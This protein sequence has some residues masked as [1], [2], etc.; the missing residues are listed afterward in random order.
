MLA[1][2]TDPSGKS[3][4]NGLPCLP[5]CLICP[6]LL[7]VFGGLFFRSACTIGR[8]R[9]QFADLVSTAGG[10][11][12]QSQRQTEIMVSEQISAHEHSLVRRLLLGLVSLVCRHPGWVLF[13]SLALAGASLGAAATRLQY[14]TQR[15]DLISPHKEHQQR[16]RDYLAEFGDDDDIVVVVKGT[17]RPRMEKALEALAARVQA[18]P[19]LFDRLFYKVDLRSLRNRALLFLSTEEIRAI[20]HHLEDMGQLLKH[21][22]IS[23]KLLTL[24]SLLQE[25]VQRTAKMKPGAPLTADDEVFLTQL[26]NITRNAKDVIVDPAKYKTPWGSLIA[27][28]PEQKDL[29]AEPQYFFSDPP[30]TGEKS[31]RPAGETLAFLLVRPIK[32]E[33]SFTYALKSVTAI[34]D[35][36]EQ[37]RLEYPGVEFGVTGLPVLETDEMTAA[38]HDTRL[39]SWLAVA[40]VSLLFLLV[41]RGIWYPLLT[42]ATLLIGTAWAL[43]WLTLTVGHLNI[44]SATFAVML[45]GMGDYGVLWVMRYEQARRA[46]ADV[47]TALL[48]TATH[49]AIGNL[50]AACTLALAF[51]AAMFADFQAVAELG[52][53]AGCGVLLCA[54]ACFTILPALLML[55][56]RRRLERAGSVSNGPSA[57]AYASSLLT[58]PATDAWLP[59]LA[60]RARWVVAAGLILMIG[61]G[62]AAWKGVRYD[63]NLLHLQARDLDSVKWE[64]TLIEHTAGANWHAVSY[65][66]TPQEALAL[67]A[68]YEK[69]PEVSRVVEAASLVPQD[70]DAKVPLLADIQRRLADL[71]KRGEVIPHLRPQSRTLLTCLNTLAEKLQPLASSACGPDGK[72]TTLLTDLRESVWNLHRQIL[73]VPAE[74][75]EKRLQEFEQRLAGDLAEDLHRL[76]EVAAPQ[77]ITLADLP[78]AFRDRY[79]GRSGKWLLRVF[80]RHSLWEFPQLEQFTQQIHAVDPTATGKPFGTVEGLRAMKNGLERAGFYA[81]LVIVAVLWLDFRSWKRTAVAVAPLVVAV[82]FSLGILGLF[83]VPLNPANMI[84]FPLILGVGVDNGVHILHDYL[85]RRRP[86]PTLPQV[87]GGQGGGISYAIGRGVLVKALTTMIGFGTLMI[88]SERGLVG[89]GLIL[90][91]GVGCSMLTAL[92]FLPAALHLWAARRLAAKPSVAQPL[93]QK[94]ALRS[95]A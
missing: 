75:V 52:W 77:P 37:T 27:R 35:I 87:G 70:Q 30:A 25:A 80:A 78:T 66:A 22:W 42:V 16:W 83:G 14:K 63:H 67:K 58:H 86:H 62:Y 73:L 53:I 93:P 71:P 21:G 79:V 3:G 29:L 41:Y 49:V 91:L 65:T 57:V 84:A 72:P 56:D 6:P 81:F 36:V 1:E 46:G 19:D 61:L 34:R 82:L 55:F 4:D 50:T 23:W 15:N 95:A 45:I 33:G 59:G 40:G 47:R 20:Q 8:T 76:R 68:R 60:R 13:V 17:D 2:T 39:A 31:A 64:L 12:S 90:T 10:R 11:A 48:H 32:E 28:P 69:L 5:A 7:G 54:F 74:V 9:L 88:A 24:S 89:L 51:F 18:Q 85:L 38:D 26:W 43:G 44:L 94:S 92:I